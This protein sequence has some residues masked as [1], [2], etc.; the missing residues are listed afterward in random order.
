MA[1]AVVSDRLKKDLGSALH[2]QVI[3]PADAGYDEV[4]KLHNGMIDK[5]PGLIARCAD[6]DDVV[7]AVKLG[8]R[9]GALVAIRSGGH[10]A[11]GL[12]S[13]DDGLLIDLSP[14]NR[15]DVDPKTREVRVQGGAMLK[16]VDSATHEHGL[17]VPAGI[18]GTTGVGGLTLGGGLGHLTRN[19]G[20]TIDNLIGAEM[21]LADGSV[22]NVD[23]DENA[24]LF[25]AIRGGGGNFG[26][27]TTFIF[28]GCP[29]K[30]VAAGPILY[31]ME[32]AADVLRF[33]DEFIANAPQ[34]LN[35]FFAFMTVPPGPPFPEELHMQK[36][37]G[38]AWTYSGDPADA[39]DALAPVRDF[40][41]PALD[42]VMEM[43]LPA[44]QTA[45]DELY[46]PGLQWYWKAAFQ[47]QLPE[48]AIQRHVEHGSA[49]PTMHS[50]MHLYPI[51]GAAA[52]VGDDETAWAYR[53][54]RWAQVIVGVDPD[55][56]N[57]PKIRQWARDYYDALLPY[58]DGGGYVNMLQGDEGDDRVQATYGANYDRLVDIKRRYDPDNFFRVNQ[59]I[60]P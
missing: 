47:S 55:P 14:M 35:G 45:F 17:A 60:A 33:Y 19:F 10:N 46:A 27:V 41:T 36:V 1:T 48:D 53:G 25:W 22:V 21:V 52:R 13:V 32:A 44:W 6:V 8:R 43:P 18:I 31:P 5:R 16:E 50:T 11:G 38:V 30:N 40:M 9:E 54:A 7:A 24:D 39:D 2:G 51:D 29:V 57:A 20:L 37:C 4:R 56:A 28:R 42:G 23:D 58:S 49:L 3:S 15:V 26:I 12:G 34:E 59:N